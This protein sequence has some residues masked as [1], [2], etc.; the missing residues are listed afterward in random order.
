MDTIEPIENKV[1]NSGLVTLD[2]EDYFHK[3][4]RVLLDIKDWLFSGDDFER[5]GFQRI[6]ENARLAAIHRKERGFHL[7]NRCNHPHLG[8]HAISCKH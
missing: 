2:L 7:F 6:R 5:K 1:A 8:I 4:E 3:G